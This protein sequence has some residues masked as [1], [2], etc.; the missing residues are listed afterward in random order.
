[1]TSGIGSLTEAADTV[2]EFNAYPA[3]AY[4]AAKAALNMFTIQYAK[5]YPAIRINCVDPGLTRT[6]MMGGAVGQPVP[7]AAA[8]IA[9]VVGLGPDGPSGKFIGPGGYVAW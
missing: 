2:A 8:V 4:R 5:A 9:R 7:E 6:D 1:M 3:D